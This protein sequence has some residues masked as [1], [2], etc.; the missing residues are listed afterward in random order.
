MKNRVKVTIAALTIGVLA[1]CG[2][3]TGYATE[4]ADVVSTQANEDGSTDAGGNN[5]NIYTVTYNLNGGTKDGEPTYRP[6]YNSESWT[7]DLSKITP[8]RD[9]YRLTG[10]WYKDTNNTEQ[11]ISTTETIYLDKLFPNNNTPT[12]T[13]EWTQVVNV[14]VDGTNVGTV[15]AGNTYTATPAASALSE[16]NLDKWVVNET[17]NIERGENGSGSITVKKKTEADKHVIYVDDSTGFGITSKNPNATLDSYWSPKNGYLV[18]VKN[19]TGHPLKF[20]K[21]TLDDQETSDPEFFGIITDLPVNTEYGYFTILKPSIEKQVIGKNGTYVEYKGY[22]VKAYDLTLN[23]SDVQ[24]NIKI[25][26]ENQTGVTYTNTIPE[27]TLLSNGLLTPQ[28]LLGI[29]SATRNGFEKYRWNYSVKDSDSNNEWIR[30]DK[31]PKN[32]WSADSTADI[33]QKKFDFSFPYY[34]FKFEPVWQCQINFETE[35]PETENAPEQPTSREQDENSTFAEFKNLTDSEK[36]YEFKGWKLEGDTSGTLYKNNTEYTVTSPSV[37]FVGQWEAI[38]YPI[39][40]N[41]GY[42]GGESTEGKIPYGEDI[43]FPID[44]TRT[45][46]TFKGWEMSVGDGTDAGTEVS[47]NLYKNGA[48]VKM[49]AKSVTMTAKWQINTYTVTYN[50]NGTTIGIYTGRDDVTYNAPYEIKNV[51]GITPTRFG[52][53]FLG[54]KI[55]GKGDTLQ[56]GSSFTM[57]ANDVT[58]VAQWEATSSKSYKMEQGVGYTYN[59]A[60]RIN[61]DPSNYQENITFY[62]PKAG[63]YTFE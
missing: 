46:Y 41:I 25:S 40:W 28:E 61:G 18:Q 20:S 60:F 12:L 21:G 26:F 2:N 5:Q 15:A 45:G 50:G 53:K 10:W 9:G 31:I 29:A 49:P 47:Q 14:T 35:F 34:E 27:R 57:P 6:T 43:K 4:S 37:T 33:L 1:M 32:V 23:A 39:H 30:A 38:G 8:E 16:W 54:W 24:R 63:E 52:Y 36:R 13:A 44:P 48:E 42:E 55:N 58:L 7:V 11:E 19:E 3:M 59:G 17:Y 62:V 22:H 56:A 51:S